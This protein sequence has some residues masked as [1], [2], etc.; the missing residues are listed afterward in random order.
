MQ[1]QEKSGAR[2]AIAAGLRHNHAMIKQTFLH[3]SGVGPKRELAIW[4][5]GVDSWETFLE[6]GAAVLPPA[7]FNLGRPVIERSLA[8]L[9]RPDGLA[10]L[11]ALVPPAEHWRFWPTYDR[12]I[13]LDIETGGDPDDWG[14]VTVVGL[15]DGAVVRQFV[16]GQ[17]IWEL[18]QAMAGADMVVTFAGTGFDLPV[19][20]G[21]FGNLRLPPVH[22]DLRWLLKRLGYGGGLKRIEKQLGI[23]RPAAVDGLGGLD[24]VHLWAR[25]LAGDREALPL[26]LEYNASDIINLEPLLALGQRQLKR[27]LLERL[28]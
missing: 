6:R 26:L 25:H 28:A 5:A 17:N 3:I 4:R 24:A 11:A 14:G 2:L 13:Y 1:G 22:V 20:R 12:V 7:V 21:V 15:Y 18:D 8:A 23:G 16:T 9:E 27:R 19:L 10:E